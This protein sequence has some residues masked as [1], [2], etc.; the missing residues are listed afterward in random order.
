[1]M[2][3]PILTGKPEGS[4]ICI[5]SF[6]LAKC[7]LE[8]AI[9]S[10][11]G[12]ICS[13]K[14]KGYC[15]HSHRLALNFC[16]L[17]LTSFGRPMSRPSRFTDKSKYSSGV[18]LHGL[19]EFVYSF[20]CAAAPWFSST[21]AIPKK[22]CRG[23][24]LFLLLA[25]SV[26]VRCS[27]RVLVTSSTLEALKTLHWWPFIISFLSDRQPHTPALFLQIHKKI[28]LN[29]HLSLRTCITKQT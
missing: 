20:C 23:V 27:V 12:R 25:L 1:M 3:L 5:K 11:I 28:L 15:S 24:L 16:T 9:K 18:M 4:C 26:S 29:V 22:F 21:S 8:I 7:E 17:T 14:D 13:G 2:L 10:T 6:S 19:L